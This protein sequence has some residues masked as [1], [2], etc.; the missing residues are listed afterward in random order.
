MATVTKNVRS[1]AVKMIYTVGF[2]II[3][4]VHKDVHHSKWDTT[5]NT[6]R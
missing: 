2:T 5:V 6:N 4:A 1:R 3:W